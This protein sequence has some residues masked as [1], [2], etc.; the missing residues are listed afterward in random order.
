MNVKIDQESL[1]ALRKQLVQVSNTCSQ[2]Q[3]CLAQIEIADKPMVPDYLAK[4][5]R[6][7]KEAIDAFEDTIMF[8]KMTPE[9]FCAY[10]Q[11]YYSN[12]VDS[13]HRAARKS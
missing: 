4:A 9:E 5:T 11:R 3:H 10:S 7:T 13:A 12:P 1:E 8:L 2:M 6:L